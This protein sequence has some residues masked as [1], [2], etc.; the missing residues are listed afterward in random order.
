MESS[1]AMVERIRKIGHHS[2]K[3]MWKD[4][5][6]AVAPKIKDCAVI[7]KD[8]YI[9][10]FWFFTILYFFGSVILAFRSTPEIAQGWINFP[11][12]MVIHLLRFLGANI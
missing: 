6:G 9:I 1:G 12:N 10:A 2:L 7:A 4:F 11:G 8:I 5:C 3:M